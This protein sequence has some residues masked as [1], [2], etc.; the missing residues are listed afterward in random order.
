MQGPFLN[1]LCSAGFDV[2]YLR[3][4]R[5]LT[6]ATELDGVAACIAGFEPYARR[7]IE[8]CPQLRMIDRN[9]VG[10]DA[11]DVAAATERGIAVTVASGANQES[12]AEHT[13]ALLL[14]LARSV[15]PQH[16][17]IRSG[18]FGAWPVFR[19]AAARWDWWDL[20]GSAGKWLSARQP[21]A[22]ASWLMSRFPML[23]LSSSS[24]LRCCRWTSSW[25][26][27]TSSRCMCR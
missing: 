2:V 26:S 13:L 11:I 4:R 20:A 17:A 22:C 1:V 14:A 6:E 15:L 18:E 3:H 12:V 10:Y 7:V 25:P 5:P 19:S 27:R 16:D 8:A 24:G 21:F 23:L 9:G